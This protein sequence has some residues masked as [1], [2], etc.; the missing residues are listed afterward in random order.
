MPDKVK[1]SIKL[2]SY[3]TSYSFDDHHWLLLDYLTDIKV[4]FAPILNLLMLD[5]I[6]I[7]VQSLTWHIA[8]Y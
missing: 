5:C 2:V 6:R 1:A 4:M 3:V 7:R 8:A